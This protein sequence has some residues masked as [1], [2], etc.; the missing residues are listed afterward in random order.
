MYNINI[1]ISVSDL[2]T[3]DLTN[4]VAI[5]LAN[6]PDLTPNGA[7]VHRIIVEEADA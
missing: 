2:E 4:A 1:E 5:A 6:S 7:K 3:L